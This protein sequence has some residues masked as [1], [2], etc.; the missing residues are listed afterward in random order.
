[1]DKPFDLRGSV[2]VPYRRPRARATSI[3]LHHNRAPLRLAAELVLAGCLLST[4][5]GCGVF[6]A[7]GNPKAAFALQEPAPMSVILRRA[8]AARATATNVDRLLKDTGVDAKSRWIPKLQLKKADVE[9]ELKEV[10]GDPDY[11]VPPNAKI[12]VLPAE[13]WAKELSELCP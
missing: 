13:A 5:A 4:T 9:A 2:A 10:S 11:A 1:R 7:I 6:S 12:R 3:M 8:A